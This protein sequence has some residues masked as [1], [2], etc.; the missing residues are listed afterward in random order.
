MQR[1]PAMQ[2]EMQPEGLL[3][4]VGLR[5]QRQEGLRGRAQ[6]RWA[7]R[8][9]CLGMAGVHLHVVGAWSVDRTGVVNL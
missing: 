6:G 8:V 9:R 5:R 7:L 3:V 4:Q 1:E 2:R